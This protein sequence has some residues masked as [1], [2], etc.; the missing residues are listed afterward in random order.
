[1]K[2]V[3]IVLVKAQL[4]S[5]RLCTKIDV[6][7]NIYL[8]DT[9]A[10]EAVKIG[11]LPNGYVLKPEPKVDERWHGK[12]EPVLMHNPGSDGIL[13]LA[14]EAY[15]CSGCGK[16]VQERQD[17]CNCGADMRE[18]KKPSKEFKEFVDTL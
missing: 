7:G 2:Y 13:G 8:E 15:S 4:D 10:G 6:F 3:D 5:G 18:S 14:Q 17:W 16:V 1:M 11:K 12:W 9:L